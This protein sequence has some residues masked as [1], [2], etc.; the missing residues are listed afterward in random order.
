MIVK[1]ENFVLH[2]MEYDTGASRTLLELLD[3]EAEANVL[4]QN[5]GTYVPL[6]TA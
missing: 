3:P 6:C 5:F 4:I 1:D 2:L